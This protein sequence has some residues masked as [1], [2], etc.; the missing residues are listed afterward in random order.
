MTHDK[1]YHALAAKQF[2]TY[3]NPVVDCRPQKEDPHQIQ[4]TAGGNLINYNGKASM[5][6]A[7]LDMAKIHWNSVVSVENAW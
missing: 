2:F 7:D 6:T 3:A 5:W 4:I 1:I